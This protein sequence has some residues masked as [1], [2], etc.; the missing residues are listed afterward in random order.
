MD[1]VTDKAGLDPV[2]VKETITYVK[3]RPGHDRRYAIDCSKLKRELSWKQTVSFEEG[4]ERTVN[5]Y[6]ENS[7]WID[8]IRSG[9]YYRWVHRNYE[10]RG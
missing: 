7:K 5:W 1:I 10:G 4:L 6:L 3:D 8:G 9:E 2:R